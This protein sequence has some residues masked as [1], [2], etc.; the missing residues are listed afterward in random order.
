MYEKIQQLLD[1]E[2]KGNDDIV[3]MEDFNAVVE[4]GKEDGYV[5]G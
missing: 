1:D 3:V 4:E 2:T 5:L